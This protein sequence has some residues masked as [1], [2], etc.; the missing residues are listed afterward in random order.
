M[1]I[2]SELEDWPNFTLEPWGELGA[3]SIRKGLRT[4]LEAT[5]Y[6][7]KLPYRRVSNPYDLSSVMR[8]ECGTCSSKHAFLAALARE[9]GYEAL[10][11]EI[12]V[13][14]MHRTNTPL[15]TALLDQ[16][17]LDAIPEA[18]CRIVLHQ[19]TYDFTFAEKKQQINPEDILET[20]LAY[21]S[22]LP[23][24]KEH[25]HKTIIAHWSQRFGFNPDILWKLRE[26]S[27]ELFQ[28]R[29]NR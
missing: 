14:R 7:W 16:Y 18:H 1:E 6:V 23:L 22:Q 2:P 8:E 17:N 24:L 19:K 26:A 21:P 28:K 12:V 27:I 3:L 10:Q 4:Y 5:I 11:L 9:H 15:I 25:I 20:H 13:Y 29:M